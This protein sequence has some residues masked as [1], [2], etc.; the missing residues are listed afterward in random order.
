MNEEFITKSIIYYL[1]E[2]D[3]IIFSFDY[4][5]SGTGFLIH[6]NDRVSKNKESMIPDI[7]AYKNNK[8]I[9]MENKSYYYEKDFIKLNE[10][11]NSIIYKNDLTNLMNRL[12]CNTLKC[13]I[14]IPENIYYLLEAESNSKLID[15]IITVDKTKSCKYINLNL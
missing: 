2:N 10:L 14:G 9:I 8:C 7:I 6:P 5:Q 15:F 13:G 12:N 1:K 4:P 11:K 3:W